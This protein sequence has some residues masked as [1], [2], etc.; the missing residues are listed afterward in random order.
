MKKKHRDTLTSILAR[1]PAADLAWADVEAL[2]TGLGAK[3]TEPETGRVAFVMSGEVR[4][5]HRPAALAAVDGG[6]VAGLRS[7]LTP[8]EV[9]S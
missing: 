3:R 2:L 9:E 6:V 1:P 4:V 5:F 7:W 8:Y